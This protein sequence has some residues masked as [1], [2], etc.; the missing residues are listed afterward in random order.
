M[1]NKK[2]N[3]PVVYKP[4]W[5]SDIISY[6]LHCFHSVIHSTLYRVLSKLLI[7]SGLHAE[8]LSLASHC[9]WDNNLNSLGNR[10]KP[11]VSHWWT[12]PSPSSQA[13][14][15]LCPLPSLT[16]FIVHQ[17]NGHLF[18]RVHVRGYLFLDPFS[19]VIYTFLWT[20]YE[21]I[22]YYIIVKYVYVC[23]SMSN[24]PSLRVPLRWGSCLNQ[25]L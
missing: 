1:F 18:I 5:S 12:C 2:L 10:Q 11:V 21:H 13:L 8:N 4:Y 9:L 24:W 6:L 7:Q 20:F 15:S 19:S 23:M 3:L 16:V 17:G 22:P 25:A 14:F